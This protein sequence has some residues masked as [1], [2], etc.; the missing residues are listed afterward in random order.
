[1][2]M[3]SA[4]AFRRKYNLIESLKPI[5]IATKMCV[6]VFGSN[7]AGYHGAGAALYAKEMMGA[8]WKRGVGRT[9]DAYALPTKDKRLRP[10][11]LERISDHVHDFLAYAS[12]HRQ[13]AFVVS[14]IGCGLAGYT[15]AQIAPLFAQA[16]GNCLFDDAWKPFLG[17]QH[18]YWGTYADQR[19]EVPSSGGA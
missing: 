6:F 5:R 2:T 18:K 12:A 17:D 7:L 15:D 4:N 3:M 8:E 1:M 10:L 14:R 11:S 9:G 19:A 16:T 13:T